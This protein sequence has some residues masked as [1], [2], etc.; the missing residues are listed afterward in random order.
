M[1]LLPMARCDPVE[2]LSVVFFTQ[3]KTRVV[4][5]WRTGLYREF[6]W[7][8]GDDSGSTGDSGGI[9]CHKLRHLLYYKPLVR[10]TCVDDLTD[11]KSAILVR[12][13]VDGMVHQVI[14]VRD[15]RGELY[16]GALTG[17][18]VSVKHNRAYTCGEYGED[19][20][21]AG[22]WFVGMFDLDDL[23]EGARARI[24]PMASPRF[25]RE[26]LPH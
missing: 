25:G 15:T 20:E 6:L 13:D 21:Y 10:N 22:A 7:T 18:A 1:T 17:L 12:T 26:A 11:E 24:E 14:T 23:K 9:Q 3:V 2:D 4:L 19:H 8:T 16:K 5:P